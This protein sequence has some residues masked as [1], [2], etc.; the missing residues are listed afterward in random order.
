MF[1][2]KTPDYAVHPGMTVQEYM[3]QHNITE[4]VFSDRSCISSGKLSRL[5]RGEEPIDSDTAILL[6]N[7]TGIKEE[8]WI[9]M[10][11]DYRV[12]RERLGDNFQVREM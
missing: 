5:L 11:E 10:E 8:L 12:A 6:A 7:V 9:R 2:P 4:E 3:E 1:E